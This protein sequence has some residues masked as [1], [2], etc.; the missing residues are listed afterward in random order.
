MQAPP[1][2]ELPAGNRKAM[3]NETTGFALARLALRPLRLA[4]GLREGREGPAR[5]GQPHERGPPLVDHHENLSEAR[6]GAEVRRRKAKADSGEPMAQ[7]GL[8]ELRVGGT[9]NFH[10]GNFASSWKKISEGRMSLPSVL[11]GVVHKPLGLA[12]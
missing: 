9:T 5:E 2:K 10:Q 8:G 4:K 3:P 6:L 11:L 1:K 7:E 12:P